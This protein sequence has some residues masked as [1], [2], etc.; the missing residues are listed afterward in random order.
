MAPVHWHSHVQN[1]ILRDAL[2]EMPA[3]VIELFSRMRQMAPAAQERATDVGTRFI[4]SSF[5]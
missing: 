1:S 3:S 4:V 5:S 2:V